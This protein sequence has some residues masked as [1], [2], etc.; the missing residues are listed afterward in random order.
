MKWV[1]FTRRTNYPKLGYLMSKLKE[2]DIP[3]R[4]DGFSFHA[5]ILKVPEDQLEPAWK[6]LWAMG[7]DTPDDAP[8]FQ[9]VGEEWPKEAV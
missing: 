8:Q 1:T 5:P 2:K 7:D 6:V 4:L 3:H 9:P